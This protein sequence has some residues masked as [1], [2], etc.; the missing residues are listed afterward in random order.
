MVAK[1]AIIGL[2]ILVVGLI[3]GIAGVYAPASTQKPTTVT[4][5]NTQ[6]SVDAN[7]YASKNTVLSKGQTVNISASIANTTTF[8]LY[9]M[10]Q[11][12]Y[13]NWY[14]C[15]PVCYQPLLGGTGTF[16][17]QA[18]ETEAALQN[19]SSLTPSSSYT[20]SFTAPS[21]GTYY[22]VLDNTI[23][24]S[25]ATYVGQNASEVVCHTNNTFACNT[26]VTL[27]LTTAGTNTTY[28]VNW[29]VVGAGAALLII[30]GAIATVMWEA[31]PA[32]KP[33]SV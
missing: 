11:T 17:Q 6:A 22:Y 16:W 10:N 31:R 19:I 14:A 33:P 4:L 24:P 25:M 30:G 9:L 21:N 23:G 15:A 8:H 26:L 32:S 5:L 13:Y 27:Q 2:I 3:V 20:G 29:P 12:Q 28:A 18:N 1:A 7:D